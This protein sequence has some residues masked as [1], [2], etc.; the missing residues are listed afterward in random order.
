MLQKLINNKI[1]TVLTVLLILLLIGV[2]AFEEV[3]FYDPFSRYFK[4][5]YLNL[6]F[7]EFNV[8]LLF[9]SLSFRY[10]LNAIFSLGIIYLIFNDIALLKF[11]TVLYVAFYL[12]LILLFFSVLFFFDEQSNFIL[13]YIR[14]LLI[15]PLF[16]LLFIPALMFQKKK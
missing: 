11:I 16:L 3:L 13:F 9:L 7:P 15:Q 10:F 12:I 6:D 4:G 8:L 5:D 14:R 2:R 1:K